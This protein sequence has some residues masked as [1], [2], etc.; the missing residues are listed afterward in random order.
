M[1]STAYADDRAIIT[2]D[3]EILMRMLKAFQRY[4]KKKVVEM[5]ME[6]AKI[7]RFRKVGGRKGDYEFC[8]G[9]KRLQII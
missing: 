2:Q 8:L 5:N 9:G 7:M 1:R 3:E 4:M 6:K